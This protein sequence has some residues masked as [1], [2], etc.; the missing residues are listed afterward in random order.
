MSLVDHPS[1]YNASGRKECIVEMVEKYGF[2]VT[3]TFCLMNAYKYFYRAGLKDGNYKQDVEKAIW[4]FKWV[5]ER[6]DYNDCNGLNMALYHDIED[7]I[8]EYTG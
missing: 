6:I 2:V 3:A 7:M 4:Y 1:H 8:I 5:S